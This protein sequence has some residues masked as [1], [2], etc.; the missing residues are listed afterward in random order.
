MSLDNL[1]LYFELKQKFE[2]FPYFAQINSDK[3]GFKNQPTA[4]QFNVGHP[5]N[6]S[7]HAGHFFVDDALFARVWN[8]PSRYFN[9]LRYFR[10]ITAPDFSCFSNTPTYLQ[11]TAI[12]RSRLLTLYFQNCGI[13][14]IPVIQYSTS[15][16]ID[17]V[18]SEFPFPIQGYLAI[19]LPGVSH[20]NFEHELFTQAIHEFPSNQLLIFVPPGYSKKHLEQFNSPNITF[21]HI[22]KKYQRFKLN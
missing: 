20:P 18:I 10:F 1:E 5:E 3:I 17:T 15:L 12:Y 9:R 6:Y 4:V 2:N 22:L 11:K 13:T 19:R 14:C 7:D 21:V 8:S 16:P